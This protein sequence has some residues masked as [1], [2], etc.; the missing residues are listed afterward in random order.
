VGKKSILILGGVRSGKS[1]FAQKLAKELGEKVLFVATGEAGDEEMQF[2][3][4][5][6]KKHRPKI[7][8]TLETPT[9]VGENLKKQIGDAEVVV[10]DCITMLVS[11]LL[12]S[13]EDNQT[14]LE[15]RVTMEIEQIVEC[16]NETDATFIIVSNEVG[17]GIVPD[18]RL[19]RLYRDLLGK[20]NQLLAQ[21]ADEVYFMVSGIPVKL[22]K[23]ACNVFKHG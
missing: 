18:N 7:W 9:K 15:K 8:R 17:M 12:V 11:N 19:S 4:E 20:A 13:E 21:S 22:K 16:T 2:R 10:I 14:E 6:H 5:E 1:N 3:I 23:T